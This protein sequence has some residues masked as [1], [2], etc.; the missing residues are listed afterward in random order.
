M[1]VGWLN[2]VWL[3]EQLVFH[4]VSI[5]VDGPPD[6]WGQMART[7]CRLPSMPARVPAHSWVLP[8]ATVTWFPVCAMLHAEIKRIMVSPA[9]SGRTPGCLS[10]GRMRELLRARYIA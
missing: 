6:D 8:Q 1:R 9:A 4:E 7:A 2:L 3:G 5:V 10:T